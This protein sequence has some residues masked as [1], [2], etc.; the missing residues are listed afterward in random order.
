[1]KRKFFYRIKIS[2]IMEI[3]EGLNFSCFTDKFNISGVFLEV[4]DDFISVVHT[5]TLFKICYILH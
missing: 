3:V 4:F 2:T 5:K 1:M